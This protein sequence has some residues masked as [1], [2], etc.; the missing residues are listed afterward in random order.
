MDEASDSPKEWVAV[1][2]LEMGLSSEAVWEGGSGLE[3]EREWEST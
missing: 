3:W 2:E 1:T